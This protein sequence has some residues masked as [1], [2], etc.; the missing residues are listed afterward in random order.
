[1]ISRKE[2]LEQGGLNKFNVQQSEIDYLQHIVLA[3][4]YKNPQNGLIF[5]GGT[6]LQKAYGLGRFSEDLDFDA[7]GENVNAFI[8]NAIKG[9]KNYYDLDYKFTENGLSSTFNLKIKGP[10]F[11]GNDISRETIRLELSKREKLLL[12]AEKVF[13][14]PSYKDLK[15]YEL[16]VMK[17]EE[18]LAE[19]I[20]ALV[21]GDRARDVYDLWFLLGKGTKVERELINKKLGLYSKGKNLA[22][23]DLAKE[24]EKER[25]K[26]GTEISLLTKTLPPFDEA[27]E[28]ILAALTK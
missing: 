11:D 7:E 8:E 13:I 27:K 2:L 5:K 14:T 15:T 24:I 18:I 12:E 3:F 22:D 21:Y 10:L 25:K 16:I 23:F 17:K 26:W 28:T 20:R 19:K 6:A 4:L 9:V 1:M